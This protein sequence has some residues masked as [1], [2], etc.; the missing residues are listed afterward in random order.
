MK[1]LL[2][3]WPISFAAF[4]QTE[5]PRPEKDLSPPRLEVHE[6]RKIEYGRG[7]ASVYFKD[8]SNVYRL[9]EN[10]KVMPC[11]WNGWRAPMKV[12]LKFDAQKKAIM[13]CQLYSGGILDIE[14]TQGPP[15]KQAQEQKTE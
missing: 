1:Y 4:S 9:S 15:K 14:T 11:L 12:L 6:V 7:K 8:F 10:D 2:L 13:D 5:D 3:L